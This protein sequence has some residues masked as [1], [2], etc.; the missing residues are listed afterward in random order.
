MSKIFILM[1]ILKL[2]D[3]IDIVILFTHIYSL[4]VTPMYFM[5]SSSWKAALPILPL[6]YFCL[7]LP[8]PTLLYSILLSALSLSLWHESSFFSILVRLIGTVQLWP[9]VSF[10]ITTNP[11]NYLMTKEFSF[12][13]VESFTPSISIV[14][15]IIYT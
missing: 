3:V 5:Q 9:F 11:F 15:C 2:L 7:F 13:I 8:Y 1:L 6:F 10:Y 12:T 14:L 4:L